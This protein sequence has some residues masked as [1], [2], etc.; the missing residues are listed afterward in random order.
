MK[1]LL[2]M[3]FDEKIGNNSSVLGYKKRTTE[4]V[5]K[6]LK[7]KNYPYRITHPWTRKTRSGYRNPFCHH[8]HPKHAQII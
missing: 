1:W 8:S 2:I 7:S 6:M 3:S 4:V 5:L